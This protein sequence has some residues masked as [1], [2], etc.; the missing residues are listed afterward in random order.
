MAPHKGNCVKAAA[1][2]SLVLGY[3]RECLGAGKGKGLECIA[4]P[5]TLTGR[6]TPHEPYLLTQIRA[7]LSYS[8]TPWNQ[9]TLT[10]STLELTSV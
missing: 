5:G 10:L 7:L 9:S 8:G 2:S 1:E 3:F 6:E 4:P